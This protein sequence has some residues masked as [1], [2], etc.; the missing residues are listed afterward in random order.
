M[1]PKRYKK[2]SDKD[3]FRWTKAWQD[4]REEIRERDKG[5]CQ[6]CIRNLYH[7]VRRIEYDNISVHHAIPIVED[8]ERRLD[9]DNLLTLCSRHHEMADAGA[10]PYDV[11]REIIEEQENNQGGSS[12]PP[13]VNF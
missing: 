7:P 6:V 4:K 12:T 13:G 1:K 2:P 10:I 9:N 3:K 5:I 11:I 8:F